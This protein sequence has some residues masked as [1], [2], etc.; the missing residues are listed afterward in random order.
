MKVVMV[1]W[2][3][4]EL[5]FVVVMLIFATDVAVKKGEV[6]K[7]LAGGA[8]IIALATPPMIYVVGWL[9]LPAWGIGA[10]PFG[11]R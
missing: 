5:I 9:L 3:A 2:L 4:I 8:F 7:A 10:I 6:T 11:G 1:T